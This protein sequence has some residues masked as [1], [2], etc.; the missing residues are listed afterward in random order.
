MNNPAEFSEQLDVDTPTS[1]VDDAGNNNTDDDNNGGA[2]QRLRSGRACTLFAVVNTNG[3][4]ARGCGVRS[5]RKVPGSAGAYEVI[6]DRNVGDCC[7]VATIGLSGGIN[8]SPT[9]QITVVGRFNNA[10]GVFVTTHNSMGSLA[11][12]GFHIA[13]HCC[14]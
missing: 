6:F 5:S 13:V 7:Y 12:R 1:A 10:N 4:L 2:A 8:S 9:G 14:C 3:T 11:D